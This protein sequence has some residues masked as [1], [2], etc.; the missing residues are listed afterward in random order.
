MTVLMVISIIMLYI[1]CVLIPVVNTA[2][3]VY[4]GNKLITVEF[5][6][7]TQSA[8]VTLSAASMPLNSEQLQQPQKGRNLKFPMGLGEQG[9]IA[10]D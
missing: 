4:C 5:L 7:L 10:K 1:K 6:L 9:D 3:H 8:I 2:F